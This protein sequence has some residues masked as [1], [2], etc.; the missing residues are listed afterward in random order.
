MHS[1]PGAES[2]SVNRMRDGRNVSHTVHLLCAVWHACLIA[3]VEASNFAQIKHVGRSEV[4]VSVLV[5][6]NLKERVVVVVEEARGGVSGGEWR[7]V[8]VVVSGGEWRVVMVVVSCT[9]R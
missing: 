3:V 1:L 4:Q 9:Q 8:V 5:T 6:G 2:N 7:V